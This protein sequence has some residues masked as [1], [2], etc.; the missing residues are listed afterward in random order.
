MAAG[1]KDHMCV[2]QEAGFFPPGTK[3]TKTVAW[4][5]NAFTTFTQRSGLLLQDVPKTLV[6]TLVRHIKA[7][8]WNVEVYAD[9]LQS[10]YLSAMLM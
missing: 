10:S 8:G 2:L 3:E 9:S 4:A 7:A 1:M 5:T 6:S